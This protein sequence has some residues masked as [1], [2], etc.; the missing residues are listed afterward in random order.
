MSTHILEQTRCYLAAEMLSRRGKLSVRAFGSSMLP[1]LWPGDIVEIESCSLADV[2]DGDVVLTVQEGRF[3]LHR[4]MEITSRG[5]D[6]Q[7]ITR[8]DS[9]PAS[10]PP[11]HLEDFLG[12]V[13]QVRHGDG[14]FAALGALSMP[15][16]MFGRILGHSEFCMRVMLWG[17]ARL[18]ATSGSGT[19]QYS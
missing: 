18:N 9:M 10:D 17:I 11:V 5:A 19:E 7:M 12:K 13:V 3:F 8:G 15:A 2:R 6:E 4:L 14:N 16:R 1:T